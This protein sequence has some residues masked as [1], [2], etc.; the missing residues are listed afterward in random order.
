MLVRVTSRFDDKPSTV[1]AC[2]SCS[3]EKSTRPPAS[4]IHSWTP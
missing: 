4:G 2:S 3:E 1:I